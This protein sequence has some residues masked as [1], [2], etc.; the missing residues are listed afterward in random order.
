MKEFAALRP[1]PYSYVRGNNDEYKKAKGTKK[2]VIK[3]K[4]KFKDYKHNVFIEEVSNIALSPNDDKR[5][6]ST[7]SIETYAYGTSECL[8]CKKGEI[9]C[10]NIIKQYKK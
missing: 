5:I 4:L 6:Q 10:S 9:K 7:D 3:R 2:S 8:I 1:K